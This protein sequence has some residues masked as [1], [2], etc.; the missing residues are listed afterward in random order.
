MDPAHRTLVSPLS[1]DPPSPINP[2]AGCRFHTRC[3]HAEAI[4]SQ[5]APVLTETGNGHQAACLM[6]QP[7]AGHSRSPAVEMIYR[8][9]LA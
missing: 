8:G 2:P 5:T 3:P 6:V 9:A 4:C 1:G 7:G